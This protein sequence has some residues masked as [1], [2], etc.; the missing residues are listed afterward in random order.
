MCP[1]GNI[2]NGRN[3]SRQF[4]GRPIRI[5][6]LTG[7]VAVGHFQDVE[8]VDRAEKASKWDLAKINRQGAVL[9]REPDPAFDQNLPVLGL[10]AKP[11]GKIVTVPIAVYSAR[12]SK[13]IWPSVA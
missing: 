5:A 2:W 11:R 13:P 7:A 6:T 9:Q 1:C 10:L 12:S 4:S 8:D 3:R